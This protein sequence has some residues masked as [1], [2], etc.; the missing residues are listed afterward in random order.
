MFRKT[1]RADPSP[2]RGDLHMKVRRGIFEFHRPLCYQYP[3]TIILGVSERQATGSRA[4]RESA[5]KKIRSQ[6]VRD[7]KVRDKKVRDKKV[8]DEKFRLRES[9]S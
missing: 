9:G 4:R 2:A 8:R 6:K 7:K 3:G 1:K 5:K